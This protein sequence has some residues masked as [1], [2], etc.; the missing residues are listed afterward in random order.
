MEAGERTYLLREKLPQKDFT[1]G[2]MVLY[3]DSPEIAN[4]WLRMDDMRKL[5]VPEADVTCLEDRRE[6]DD[7][8]IRVT[9]NTFAHAVHVDGNWKCSDNYFDLLP[10]EEKTFTVKD[11]GENALTVSAVNWQSM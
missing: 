1:K 8:I 9:C 10:G 2:T 4:A 3:V 11:A 7:R 6:G 5:A